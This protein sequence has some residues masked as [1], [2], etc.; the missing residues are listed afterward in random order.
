MDLINKFSNVD[1]KNSNRVPNKIKETLNDLYKD[2]Q[3]MIAHNYQNLSMVA[4]MES[5]GSGKNK[6][7][8]Y[9]I[10]KED[11]IDSIKTNIRNL[12]YSITSR[13]FKTFSNIYNLDLDVD[14]YEYLGKNFSKM[15]STRHYEHYNSYTWEEIESYEPSPENFTNELFK[16]IGFKELN[17][18]FKEESI[19]TIKDKFTEGGERKGVTVQKN[20]LVSL[21]SFIYNT[22]SH[23]SET[24]NVKYLKSLVGVLKF[25][26]IDNGFVFDEKFSL[27]FFLEKY[28]IASYSSFNEPDSL[29]QKIEINSELLEH[30]QYFKNGKYK[31]KFSSSE[32]AYSFLRFL[33]I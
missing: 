16:L 27:Y 26:H 7:S 28:G 23:Y 31:L 10:S 21:E 20:G 19:Q 17:Q 1:V 5:L 25:W 32:S 12:K 18:K 2:Y 8:T 13:Y 9:L 24:N 30:V 22:Q 33:G 15:Y 11:T 29:Y 14:K 3:E 6:F 4:K